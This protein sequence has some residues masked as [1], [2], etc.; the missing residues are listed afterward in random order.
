MTEY[1]EYPTRENQNVQGRVE[2]ER[3]GSG[4]LRLDGNIREAAGWCGGQGWV[5]GRLAGSVCTKVGTWKRRCWAVLQV[6]RPLSGWY[7]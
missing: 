6:Q 5:D 7:C 1:H 3:V 4:C 2:E